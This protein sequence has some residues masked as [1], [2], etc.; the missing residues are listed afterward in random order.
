MDMDH[1]EIPYC[2]CINYD[3]NGNP[4]C[5]IHKGKLQE[6]YAKSDALHR[7]Y[8]MPKEIVVCH[9]IKDGR[10]YCNSRTVENQIWIEVQEYITCK[11]CLRSELVTRNREIAEAQKNFELERDGVYYKMAEFNVK[12]FITKDKIKDLK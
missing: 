1:L 12:P 2:D 4:R 8:R 10:P 7:S 6:F 9:S 3:R 11:N 5:S